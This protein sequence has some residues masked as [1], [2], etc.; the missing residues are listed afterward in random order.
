MKGMVSKGR[1]ETLTVI[2]PPLPLQREF[3]RQFDV[4][5]GMAQ[6]MDSAAQ[7]ADDL[8]NSLVQ[9]AFRGEL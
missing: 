5:V 8:F 3:M 7:E 9:R 4:L 1:F 2:V 6:K